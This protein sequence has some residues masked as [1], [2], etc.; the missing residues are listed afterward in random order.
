MTRELRKQGWAAGRRGTRLMWEN[1]LKAR[2]PR[3][4]R[5]I[6]DSGHAFPIAPNHLNQNFTVPGPDWAWSA[7]ISDVWMWEGW[8][9]VA[10]VLD[11]YSRRVVGWAAGD[12]L[13]EELALT[14]LRRA[15]VVRQ[16][17]PD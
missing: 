14:A 6:T 9:S 4:F 8:L 17:G 2:Q 3:C 5:R 12:H 16:P 13:H 10:V 15:L 11:L 1:G 7:D